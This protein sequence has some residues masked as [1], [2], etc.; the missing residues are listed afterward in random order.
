MSGNGVDLGAI[1]GPVLAIDR[2]LDGVDIRFS[3]VEVQV[4]QLTSDMAGMK[5]GMSSMRTGIATSRTDLATYHAAV[6]GHGILISELDERL[7]RLEDHL[8]LTSAA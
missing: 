6:T 4:N 1:Y 8:G 3:R 2:K 7:R 5:I